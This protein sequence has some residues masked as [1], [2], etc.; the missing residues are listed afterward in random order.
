MGVINAVIVFFLRDGFMSSS[1]K[2]TTRRLGFGYGGET[3]WLCEKV[4]VGQCTARAL[5]GKMSSESPA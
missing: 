4:P 2:K 5:H 3:L 1:L